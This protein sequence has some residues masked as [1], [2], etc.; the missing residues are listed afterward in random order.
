MKNFLIVFIV[1]LAWS[2][3]AIWLYTWIEPAPTVAKNT[4]TFSAQKND[5]INRTELPP[6]A[7][8]EEPDTLSSG[9]IPSAVFENDDN[10]PH[11]GIKGIGKDGHE[12]FNFAEGVEIHKNSATIYVPVTSRPYVERIKEYLIENTDQEVHLTMLYSPNENFDTPNLGIQRGHQIKKE[13]VE[14]G[15]ASEKIVVKSTIQELQFERDGA[16]SSS[17]IFT[18]A[19]YD[20]NRKPERYLDQ[21]AAHNLILYPDFSENG[22]QVNSQLK[23]ALE[24]IKNKLMINPSMQVTVAGHTDNVGNANDNYKAGLDYARQVRWY[25]VNRG[26]I[27]RDKVRA[28]S[29]GESQ[30][31]ASN[32]TER[33]RALNRRIEVIFEAIN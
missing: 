27:A 32:K 4:Q 33:G 1:F 28:I 21:T 17:V 3:F 18:F 23:Q 13:L 11:Q 31:I 12:L 7:F 29:H 10:L 24:T 30:A 9:S 2:I 6:A 19:D 20:S 8:I 5:T 14:A 26:N 22:I 16:F 25:F 15:I